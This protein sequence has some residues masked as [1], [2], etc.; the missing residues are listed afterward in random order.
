MIIA[1]AYKA[2]SL[3]DL[4]L[5]RKI[6]LGLISFSNLY[7]TFSI[8]ALPPMRQDGSEGSI[9]SGTQRISGVLI[10]C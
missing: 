4:S 8:Q 5:G 2:S 1:G 7:P 3:C 6:T 10:G 9:C